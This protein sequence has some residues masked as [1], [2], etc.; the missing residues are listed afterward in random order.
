VLDLAAGFDR[1][2][3]VRLGVPAPFDRPCTPA[4]VEAFRRQLGLDGG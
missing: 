2:T 1:P 4:E 3:L